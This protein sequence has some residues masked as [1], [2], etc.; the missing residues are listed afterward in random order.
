MQYATRA[1]RNPLG[2]WDVPLEVNGRQGEWIFDT[3]ANLSTLTE[4][5]AARMGLKPQEADA[6]VNGSTGKKN[7]L[8][9]AVAQDLR[10]GNAHLRN[11]LFLIL[12]DQALYIG[13]LKSQIR[14]IL[15][16]PV[17]RALGRNF[18]AVGPR[19]D[20]NRKIVFRTFAGILNCWRKFRDS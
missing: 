3:G 16:L 18:R 20:V 19:L 7:P 11:V 17:L 10:S 6:Y 2:S 8:R 13:P 5:E 12:S 14:G 4:S 15:G 9:F 1:S